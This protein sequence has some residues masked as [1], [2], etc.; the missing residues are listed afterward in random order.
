MANGNGA[1]FACPLCHGLLAPADGGPGCPACR[2]RF[3]ERDGFIDFAPE[4]E[5]QP[6]LGQ[7]LLDSAAVTAIYERWWRPALLRLASPIRNADEEAYLSK[8]SAPGEG[9]VLDLACGTGYFS[10]FLAGKVGARRVVG[11]D[12]SF[13]MLKR[14]RQEALAAGL[15]EIALIRGSALRLPFADGRLA[16]VNCSGALHLFPDPIKAVSEVGRALKSGGTFTCLTLRRRD[17]VF[18]RRRQ[19]MVSR[20]FGLRFFDDAVI[21]RALEQHG[22]RLVDSQRWDM[23]LLFAARKV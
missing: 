4:I 19:A 8:F 7:R 18:W 13:A 1:P 11:L 12:L 14:A 23:V 5:S 20:L 22:M 6:G 10:R 15:A 17:G 3:P 2:T 16:S 21:P 9:P